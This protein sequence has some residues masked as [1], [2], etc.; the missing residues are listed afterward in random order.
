MNDTTAPSTKKKIVPTDISDLDTLDLGESGVDMPVRHVAP[1]Y[2]VIYNN[3][4]VGDDP[5]AADYKEPTQ[6]TIT[7]ASADSDKFQKASR[8][9]RNRRNQVGGRRG[10]AGALPRAEEIDS[11][12]IELLVAVVIRWNITLRGEKPPCTPAKVREVYTKYP[13]IMRQVD[14]YIADDANF[15]KPSAQG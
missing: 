2:A 1:P 14:A 13:W 10:G 6:Q 12:S 15:L 11:D 3:D 9:A 8:S 5:D 4:G 7:V